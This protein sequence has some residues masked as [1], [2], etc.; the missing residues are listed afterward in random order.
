M[1]LSRQPEFMADGSASPGCCY[2]CHAA[3]RSYEAGVVDFHL[4]VDVAVFDGSAIDGWL[5]ACESCIA[6]MGR[7]I[8]MV[9]AD[10]ADLLRGELA[11]ER[12]RRADAEARLD[13]ADKALDALSVY[14]AQPRRVKGDESLGD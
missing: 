5:Q 12:E 10:Q 13:E 1:I 3:K 4:Q 2:F 8:G 6:E 11:L 7:L 14:R 9:D